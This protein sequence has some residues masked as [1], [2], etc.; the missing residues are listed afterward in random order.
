MDHCPICEHT[1]SI[2]ELDAEIEQLK[3]RESMSAVVTGSILA[4]RTLSSSSVSNFD[5]VGRSASALG[6]A[7]LNATCAKCGIHWTPDVRH[8]AKE[9][10]ER[11]REL[12]MKLGGPVEAIGDLTRA[13]LPE[14]TTPRPEPEPTP[15][16]FPVRS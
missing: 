8:Q 5:L 6:G 12:K 10:V 4:G 16:Q 1:V 2:Q 14:P 7:G 15:A 13:E 9:K 11:I 3:R